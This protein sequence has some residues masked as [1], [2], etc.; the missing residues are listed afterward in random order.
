[1]KPET[2]ITLDDGNTYLNRV[3]LALAIIAAL[4]FALI[5][6]LGLVDVPSLPLITH[7]HAV[8]MAS[9]LVLIAVQ[10]HLGSHGS[11]ALHKRLGKFGALLALAVV[12]TGLMTLV[13]VLS[14]GRVPPIFTSGY[15]LMLGIMNLTGFSFC[16]GA[17]LVLRKNTGWH[18]RLML[19][20]LI[21]IYEPALGRI[22]PFFLVPILGAT[23]ENAVSV[24][25]ENRDLI[26]TVRVSVHLSIV[27]IIML[28]D[29]LVTGRFHPIYAYLFV[30]VICVY[31]V[32]NGIGGL[33]AVSEFAAYVGGTEALIQGG[34][35]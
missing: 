8:I 1:M 25:M 14:T 18:R 15:F 24:M 27:T 9:W 31:S 34:A 5:S 26:D 32:A 30:G 13:D 7:A 19:G 11:I 12:A 22:L 29:R 35:Q 20:S 28:G 3:L 4:G 6:L 33:P 10:S 16:V 2:A 23:P 17:A 21:L